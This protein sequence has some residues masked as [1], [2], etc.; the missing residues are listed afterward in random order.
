MPALAAETLVT[1][2]A[3]AYREV[4][5]DE[6]HA[7]LRF[8]HEAATATQAQAKVNQAMQQGLALTEQFPTVATATGSYRVYE[9]HQRPEEK[10]KLTQPASTWH[11]QQS[12]NLSGQEADDLLTL[13]GQLQEAGFNM[14]GLNYSLSRARGEQLKD[15]LVGEA[16]VT[17]KNRAQTMADLL[18]KPKVHFAKIAVDGQLP[19]PQPVPYMAKTM[20]L[21]S[22]AADMG[23]PSATAGETTVQV[24]VQAEVILGN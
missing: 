17:L 24:T 21:E 15:A 23:A 5:Q 12:L 7:T 4:T 13:A 11:A 16:L 18:G 3:T 10:D 22:M 1:L 2:S 9:R 8:E 19:H 20:R 6:L 14:A